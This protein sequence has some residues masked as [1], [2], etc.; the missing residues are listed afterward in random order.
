[1]EVEITIR[2]GR[3]EAGYW[4]DLWRYRELF[5]FLAWRDI[6]VRYK[7]T[8]AGSTWALL[9]PLLT[10]M[11]FTVLFGR[12]GKFHPRAFRHVA[13]AIFQQCHLRFHAQPGQ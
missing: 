7:Q 5:G 10:T 6:I 8:V 4:R 13:L 11:V 1:M 12:M 2:A 9:R 3:N